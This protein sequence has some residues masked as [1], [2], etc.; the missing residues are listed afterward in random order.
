MRFRYPS[1]FLKLLL[2][3]FAFAILPL[4][5][6]F[7]NANIAF[8]RL[9]K[10]SELTISNAVETTRASRITQEQLR[11]MERSVR[12]YF[13]LQ[14]DILFSNYL[15][16]NKKYLTATSKL[17]QLATSNLQ[18][19]RL[20]VLLQRSGQ[21]NESILNAKLTETPELSFLDDF[22]MLAE[23]I[24]IIIED[25]SNAID[26]T[27]SELTRTAQKTQKNLLLQSLVL[28][29]L[30]LLVAGIITFLLARP[31]RRMDGAIRDL[32]E[33]KY[34]EPIAIDG[35]GDLRVLG[36]RLD[37]LRTEL[38]ELNTQ[39]QQFLQHVSHELKTP[40]TAIREA[41]EL[42]NDGIGG[43]LTQQQYEI[44]NI[45]RDNS[46]RLQKM[47]ENL[48]N[49]TKMDAIQT[50]LNLADFNFADISNKVI[51]AHALS[52]RNKALNIEAAYQLDKNIVADEEKLTIIL[53]NLIS[54][55]VKYTPNAGHI[56]IGAKQEK[57][58]LIIEVQDSGP[59]LGKDDQNKL[60][61]PF[62]QG[63]SVHNGLINGSGLGLTIAKN[64]AETH[65]GSIRLAPSDNG[66]HFVV[67]IPILDLN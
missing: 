40:L 10:Q 22:S 48:L 56:K 51:H 29:P 43:A 34:D 62:Y 9:A 66:A 50:N 6:A 63:D 7:A 46:V 8:D 53:D 26:N 17:Q 23:Q 61:D 52:I 45:L 57:K 35:P 41:A 54:N 58:W 42:L 20:A 60:F 2:F 24:D 30:A 21:L 39:K 44:T 25:N 14:D 38:K 13:V 64:L 55:A 33:R 18:Q 5:W 59:G 49:Y 47:I 31:I 32:G 37:W 11:L 67:Q 3:G 28:I 12:Q 65:H 4:L 15:Q 36:R 1:S 27:S 16:A 19:Q